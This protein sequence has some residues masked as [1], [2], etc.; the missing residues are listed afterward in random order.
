MISPSLHPLPQ[1]CQNCIHAQIPSRYLSYILNP[2]PDNPKYLTSSI[3]DPQPLPRDDP[4]EPYILSH[5]SYIP[6]LLLF[7]SSYPPYDPYYPT[8]LWSLSSSPDPTSYTLSLL[9]YLIL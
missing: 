5:E 9:S 2:I 4:T 1:P 6:V 8:I 7:L 3:L